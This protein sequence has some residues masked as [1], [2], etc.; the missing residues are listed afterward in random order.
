MKEKLQEINEGLQERLKSPFVVTF[1]IVWTVRHWRLVF[2]VFSFDNEFTQGYK[3]SIIE[4]YIYSHDGWC[5]MFWMPVI[6][7]FGSILFYYLISLIYE[8]L[9]LIYSKYGRPFIN[10]LDS[11][12]LALSED[13]EKER[14]RIIELRKDVKSLKLNETELND[15]IKI[16]QSELDKRNSEYSKIQSDKLLLE[17][18]LGKKVDYDDIKKEVDILKYER[19]N[20]ENNFIKQLDQDNKRRAEYL[21]EISKANTLTELFKNKYPKEYQ[22][23]YSENFEK[24]LEKIQQNLVTMSK[25]F[26]GDWDITYTYSGEKKIFK[27]MSMQSD[28]LMVE[29]NADKYRITEFKFDA[30]SKTIIFNR[31]KDLGN[32]LSS[33]ER[34]VLKVEND[35]KYI[36]TLNSVTQIEFERKNGIK[37]KLVNL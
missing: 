31:Y 1:L 3:K 4:A 26:E 24:E 9:N 12:R 33:P 7:S 35:K 2:I 23:I 16:I 32:N 21:E 34:I 10:Q 17:L 37:G 27:K 14:D 30:S 13:L 36:G 5:G 18:E 8:A 20:L 11:N 19:S 25:L 22:E 6:Y 28:S 29:N 15:T